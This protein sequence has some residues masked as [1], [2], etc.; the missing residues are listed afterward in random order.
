MKQLPAK[1]IFAALLIGFLISSLLFFFSKPIMFAFSAGSLLGTLNFSASH[2]IGSRTINKETQ[3]L[4]SS[5]AALFIIRFFIFISLLYLCVAVFSLEII[6][7]ISGISLILII[8]FVES[9][10][11]EALRPSPIDEQ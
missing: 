11:L 5:W 6:P 7:F 10:R 1:I 3:K 2:Y 9:L 8:I 4:N